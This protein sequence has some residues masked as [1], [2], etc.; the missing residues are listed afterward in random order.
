M[1]EI[2]TGLLGAIG[3]PFAQGSRVDD[4]VRMGM[5]ISSTAGEECE[6]QERRSRACGRYLSCLVPRLEGVVFSTLRSMVSATAA[7]DAAAPSA[8][9]IFV[10]F[11]RPLEAMPG[12][13]S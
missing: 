2:E 9:A 13:E 11:L 10:R 7:N 4:D 8:M 3:E 12:C 1:D 6:K 5:A